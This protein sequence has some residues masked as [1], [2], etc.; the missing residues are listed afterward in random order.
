MNNVYWQAEVD[1]RRERLT[2]DFQAARRLGLGRIRGRRRHQRLDV[3]EPYG[4][5]RA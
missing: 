5:A 3:V 2:H 1:Y 4:D